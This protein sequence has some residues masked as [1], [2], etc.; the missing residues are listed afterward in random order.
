MDGSVCALNETTN[1]T[2]MHGWC[3]PMEMDGGECS[4]PE[5]CDL[6]GDAACATVDCVDSVCVT[7]PQ[8]EALTC[9][10]GMGCVLDS[11]C[12]GGYCIG[13]VAACNAS[14]EME[15]Q[16]F[17]GI[18]GDDG[19]CYFQTLPDGSDCRGF[20]NE[21]LFDQCFETQEC[22]AGDCTPMQP[23]VCEETLEVMM[24]PCLV[25]VCNS[26]H[27]CHEE[28]LANGTYC[29]SVRFAVTTLRVER[30]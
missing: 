5:D 11:T 4:V 22:Y 14:A 17:D 15:C 16:A 19:L 18:C 28:E 2:C 6:N 23:V 8:N 26:T 25:A 24:N 29:P 9:E 13:D 10:D 3:V 1:G 27:G 30:Y 21:T 20:S 7:T 12:K